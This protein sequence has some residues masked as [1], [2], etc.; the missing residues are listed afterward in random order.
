MPLDAI[1]NNELA[2]RREM[3]DVFLLAKDVLSDQVSAYRAGD[4]PDEQAAKAICDRLRT[5]AQAPAVLVMI[6]VTME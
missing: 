5:L 6:G 1:R 2:L 3:V 4:A